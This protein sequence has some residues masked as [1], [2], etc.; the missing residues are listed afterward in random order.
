MSI[1]WT[2]SWSA[3]DDGTV[4]GGNDIGNLQNDIDTYTVQLAG[5]QTIPGNKTFSGNNTFSGNFT[6][7]SNE[8]SS[9]LAYLKNVAAQLFGDTEAVCYEN[10]IVCYENNAVYYR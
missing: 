4:F 5:T 2:K 8:L 9:E 10:A 6:I 1:V 7:G 3:S